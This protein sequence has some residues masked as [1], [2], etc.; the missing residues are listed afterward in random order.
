MDAT[1]D[2]VAGRLE[3]GAEPEGPRERI[4]RREVD[5][6][7]VEATPVG[8]IERRV[9]ESAANATSPGRWV[10]GGRPDVRLT[11]GA[12]PRSRRGELERHEADID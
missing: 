6:D 2:A 8:P 1:N 7:R 12:Q 9:D 4:G 3:A 5:R 11:I 10:D